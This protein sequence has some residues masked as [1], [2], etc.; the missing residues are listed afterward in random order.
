MT[1]IFDWDRPQTLHT[2]NQAIDIFK[3]TY[4]EL[5]K[6]WNRDVAK[7]FFEIC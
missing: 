5:P 2:I 3:T 6:S 7:E 1:D 4:N